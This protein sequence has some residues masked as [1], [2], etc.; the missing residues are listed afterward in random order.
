MSPY[1]PRPGSV[2]TRCVEFFQTNPEEVLTVDDIAQ[3]F[4]CVRNNVHSLL[5]QAV[6][7]ELLE[8]T[9]NEDGDYVYHLRGHTP[10]NRPSKAAA[11]PQK[12]AEPKRTKV[13]PARKALDI[14]KLKV[15]EGIPFLEAHT[16]G[17]SKWAPLFAKLTKAGQSIAVPG[18]MRGA[19]GAAAN[20]INGLKTQGRYRVAMVDADTARVWRIA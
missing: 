3:K 1:A 12:A 17:E 19:V 10:A 18:D 16:K 6:E 15:E 13:F 5:A 14:S 20:K 7:N 2:S 4:D 9:R 8:R 11:A